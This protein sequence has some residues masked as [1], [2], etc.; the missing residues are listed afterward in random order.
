MSDL[1]T[2]AHELRAMSAG[3]DQAQ[4]TAAAADSHAQEVTARAAMS[5]FVG[6]A[7][8]MAQVAHAIREIRHRLATVG[9]HLNQAL[10]PVSGAGSR[11]SPPGNHPAT[12]TGR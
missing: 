1:E 6:I 2:I 9:Q 10:A 11:P 12:D 8:G 4:Q 7:A 3:I 5:G